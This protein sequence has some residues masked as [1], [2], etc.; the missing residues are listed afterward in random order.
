VLIIIGL[1]LYFLAGSMLGDSKK[2]W[3]GDDQEEG[4]A[5]VGTAKLKALNLARKQGLASAEGDGV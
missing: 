5:G 1:V 4:V 2:P 3:L